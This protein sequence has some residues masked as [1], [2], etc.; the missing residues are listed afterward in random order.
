[1]WIYTLSGDSYASNSYFVSADGEAVLIDPS[2]SVLSVRKQL[3]ERFIMPKLLILTHAHFDHML[4][5]QEWR[6]E[7]IPL[8]V[9]EADR[10]ALSDPNKSYFRMFLGRDDVFSP[11]EQ[12]LNEGR[13]I[14]LGRECLKVMHTPG[15]TVGSICLC[16]PSVIFTGD[17]VFTDGGYGRTDLWGGDA[18]TLFASIRRLSRLAREDKAQTVMYAGHGPDGK[19]ADEMMYFG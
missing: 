1:M 12:L 16:A 18:A 5:L 7:G 6:D 15:H 8:C 11:P 2:V 4:A 10:F 13:T 17:T 19:F 9:H 14:T 3:G